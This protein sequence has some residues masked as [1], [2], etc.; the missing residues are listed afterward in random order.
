VTRLLGRLI[1]VPLVAVAVAGC[2]MRVPVEDM[3]RRAPPHGTPVTLAESC[4]AVQAQVLA[5][6]APA[7]LAWGPS[8]YAAY[9]GPTSATTPSGTVRAAKQSKDDDYWLWWLE[10]HAGDGSLQ[11]ATTPLSSEL[12]HLLLAGDVVAVQYEANVSDAFGATKLWA[13][14]V[15][16][17]DAQAGTE[18]WW[19]EGWLLAGTPAEVIVGVDVYTPPGTPSDCGTT[20]YGLDRRTGAT[21][22]AIGLPENVLTV[23]LAISDGVVFATTW[24]PNDGW[25]DVVWSWALATDLPE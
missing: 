16:A 6:D 22:W 18:L 8:G 17:V 14:Y 19:T 7:D 1:A 21:R 3:I 10:S 9:R 5:A 11:W 25:G 2:G 15:A 23:R 24:V 12:R 20:V 13:Q 4:S